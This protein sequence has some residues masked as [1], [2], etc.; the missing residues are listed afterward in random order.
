MGPKAKKHTPEHLGRKLAEIRM[1]LGIE[2]YEKMI[3]RLNVKEIP[4]HRASIYKYEQSLRE[5]PLIVLLRYAQLAGVPMDK[6]VDDSQNLPHK[7]PTK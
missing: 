3:A 1:K 5:P 6:L 2:T 4:L 7:L